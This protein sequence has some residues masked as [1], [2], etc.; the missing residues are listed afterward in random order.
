MSSRHQARETATRRSEFQPDVFVAAA[1]AL[2]EVRPVRRG[3]DV[4]AADAVEGRLPPLAFKPAVI[5][6]VVVQPEPE[7]E[8]A[9]E[10]AENDRAGGEIEHAP[11]KR[12]LAG[13]VKSQP[14]RPIHSELTEGN[15]GPEL[16]LQEAAEGTEEL[17]CPLITSLRQGSGWQARINADRMPP[18]PRPSAPS[19]EK[20]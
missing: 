14:N 5:A 9:H 7:E 3:V 6:A 19:A 4:V 18:D 10:R 12:S 1:G 2:A 20:D 8:Q 15:E 17:I 16:I 11:S 13:A